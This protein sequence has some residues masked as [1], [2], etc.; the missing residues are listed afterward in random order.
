GGVR[1]AGARAG[2][3]AAELRGCAQPGH[4]SELA[5][6]ERS[7]C[8]NAGAPHGAVHRI[9]VC[10]NFVGRKDNGAFEKWNAAR[11]CG[12]CSCQARLRKTVANWFSLSSECS[13]PDKKI[14]SF[15]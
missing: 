11:R 4:S 3:A 8:C 13:R 1:A 12:T 10:R 2:D 15:I 6:S 9:V 7:D 14:L 5:V